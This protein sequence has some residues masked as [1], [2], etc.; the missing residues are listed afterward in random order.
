VTIRYKMFAA[1]SL[2]F[3]TKILKP[4]QHF[5]KNK[6]IKYP[7]IKINSVFNGN[8]RQALKRRIYPYNT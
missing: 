1:A 5:E 3:D 2:H 8:S 4:E 6:L 7:P